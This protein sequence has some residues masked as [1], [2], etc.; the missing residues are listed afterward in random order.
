MG[1]SAGWRVVCQSAGYL[2]DWFVGPLTGGLAGGQYDRY[3]GILE[4]A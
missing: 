1:G 4:D 3:A 2:A